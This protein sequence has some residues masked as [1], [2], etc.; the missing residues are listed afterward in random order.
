MS[1]TDSEGT[2]I[3][4]TSAQLKSES[5]QRRLWLA[6]ANLAFSRRQ[7]LEE[8]VCAFRDYSGQIIYVDNSPYTVPDI[9]TVFGDD[10]DCRWFSYYKKPNNTGT[11]PRHPTRKLQRLEVLAVFC[12]IRFPKIARHFD[13]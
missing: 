8:I 6:I 2:I 12:W 13:R 11:G 9:D 5:Y 3:V 4:P 1:I 10:P 7:L